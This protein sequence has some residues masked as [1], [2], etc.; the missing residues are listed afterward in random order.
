MSIKLKL[1]IVLGSFVVLFIAIIGATFMTVSSQKSDGTVINTAGRQRML[2]QKMSKESMALLQ[3]KSTGEEVL[4]TVALFDNSL[5]ALISG[6]A[7]MGIPA[8][9]DSA[10]LAQLNKVKDVWS[11]FKV[12]VESI[13]ERSGHI[14]KSKKHILEN[15]I[16]LPAL[17]PRR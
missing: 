15:N 1:G 4:K 6:N 2:S 12:N 8:T 14:E 3:G 10:T 7:N 16:P 17:P 9:R 13:V 11:E 5:N